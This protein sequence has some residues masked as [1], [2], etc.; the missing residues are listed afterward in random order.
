MP[1]PFAQQLR[2]TSELHSKV[3]ERI[4]ARALLSAQAMQKLHAKW[5]RAEED[6]KAYAPT[7]VEDT[8]RRAQRSKGIHEYTTIIVPYSYASLLAALTYWSSVFFSRAPIHQYSS[9]HGQGAMGTTAME[10]LI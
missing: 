6:F 4:L 1:N 10:S 2:Y 9:R 5:D 7:A 3:R 8:R